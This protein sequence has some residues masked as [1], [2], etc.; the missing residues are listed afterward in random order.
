MEEP[1]FPRNVLFFV[2]FLAGLQPVESLGSGVRS[3]LELQSTAGSLT[4][5]AG[6]GIGPASQSS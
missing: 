6:L 3:E 5:C 2:F 1:L 4:C